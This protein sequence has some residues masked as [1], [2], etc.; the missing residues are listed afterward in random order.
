MYDY[1]CHSFYSGDIPKGK[2]STFDELCESAVG[3][4]IKEIAVTD[5][6]DI[7][8]IYEGYFPPLDRE[9]IYRDFLLSREKFAGKLSLLLGIELGQA[10]HLPAE[11]EKCLSDYPYDVV[12]GSIHAVRGIIDFADTDL[13]TIGSAGREALWEK[14]LSE[15]LDTLKW[16]NFDILAHITYPTRY[17][18]HAGITDFP[19]IH[20][21]GREY[22][23]PILREVIERGIALECNTSGLRQGL[24]ETLPGYDLLKYY[25]ELGGELVTIGSDAHNARDLGADFQSAE[26]MLSEIGF[27]YVTRIKNREK[28]M[29]SI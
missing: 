22:F 14:Y 12:I 19:D 4:G 28:Y 17:Y 1:H 8:G 20:S 3:K 23:K 2:G 11:S 21:K 10:S 5:H 9:G 16:G 25:F 7:D 6:F 24:G 18:R 29:Q 15:M 13:I 26:K 27:G